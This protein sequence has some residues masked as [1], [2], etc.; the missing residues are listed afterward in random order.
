MEIRQKA[1]EEE[2]VVCRTGQKCQSLGPEG[3]WPF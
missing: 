1:L 3:H 2:G